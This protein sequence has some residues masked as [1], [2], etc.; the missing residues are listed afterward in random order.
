MSGLKVNTFLDRIASFRQEKA[1]GLQVYHQRFADCSFAHLM[2]WL[3]C[4][5]KDTLE[6]A[7]IRAHARLDEKANEQFAE[8]RC[9]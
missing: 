4:S 8:H 3:L 7:V 5:V 1:A 6:K 2:S 9:D